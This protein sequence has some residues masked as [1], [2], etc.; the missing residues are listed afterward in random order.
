MRK[1]NESQIFL[2]QIKIDM[3]MGS[4]HRKKNEAEKEKKERENK[5]V[6]KKNQKYTK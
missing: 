4:A 3:C 6:G 1:K 5:D 2:I